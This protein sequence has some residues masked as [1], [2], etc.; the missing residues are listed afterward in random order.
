MDIALVIDD[1]ARTSFRRFLVARVTLKGLGVFLNLYKAR[2]GSP[3]P[4]TMGWELNNFLCHSNVELKLIEAKFCK[5]FCI[6]RKQ[7]KCENKEKRSRKIFFLRKMQNF[8]ERIF[9]FCWKPQCYGKKITT[10]PQYIL[11]FPP[12]LL[13]FRCHGKVI[14]YHHSIYFIYLR[15]RSSV[16]GTTVV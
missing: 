11:H 9:P 3:H 13:C 2:W 8:C 1:I 6:L 16:V 14:M 10:P 5:I 12:H 7:L 15:C 4:R